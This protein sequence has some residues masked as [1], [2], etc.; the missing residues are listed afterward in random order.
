MKVKRSTAPHPPR[1]G[2]SPGLGTFSREEW[3]KGGN[4]TFG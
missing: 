3:E 2:S 1:P 4:S